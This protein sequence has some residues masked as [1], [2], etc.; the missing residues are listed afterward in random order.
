MEIVSPTGWAVRILADG[1]FA[2]VPVERWGTDGEPLIVWQADTLVDARD[3]EGFVEL[4]EAYRQVLPATPGWTLRKHLRHD[5]PIDPT[6]DPRP[7]AGWVVSSSFGVLRP[8]AQIAETQPAH[9]HP[10][11]APRLGVWKLYPPESP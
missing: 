6:E 11:I 3:V 9:G 7:V 10:E 1:E 4:E 8:I 2:L 5:G